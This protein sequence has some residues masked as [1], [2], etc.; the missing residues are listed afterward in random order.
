MDITIPKSRRLAVNCRMRLQPRVGRAPRLAGLSLVRHLRVSK[1]FLAGRQASFI[2]EH[3]ERDAAFHILFPNE[4]TKG[5]E[6][7]LTIDYAG[8]KVVR[9]AGGGNFFI[10]ARSSWYPNVGAFS[11]RSTFDLT[12]HYPKGFTLVSVGKLVEELKEG[13]TRTARWSSEIPPAVVG[14]N[15]HFQFDCLTSRPSSGLERLYS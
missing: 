9:T 3:K 4:L 2:Q 1:V 8:D 15:P 6:Y 11:D 13:N 10:R 7:E 12:F 5:E 14:F